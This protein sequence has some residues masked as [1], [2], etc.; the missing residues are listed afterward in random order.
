MRVFGRA[1]LRYADVMSTLAVF[2]ALGGG[3]LAALQGLPGSRGVFHG[4]VSR[5]SGALR[6]VVKPSA[7][8]R[9]KKGELAVSWNQQGLPGPATGTAG[10]DLSG[11]YP[12][13]IIAAGAVTGAKIA[14]GSVTAANV[15][16]ANIDGPPA[17]PSLRTLG[18][19]AQ[20][21]AAGDDPRL[22]TG[23]IGVE[24]SSTLAGPT[25][26]TFS[27]TTHKAGSVLLVTWSGTAFST[28]GG[29]G[30]LFLHVEVSPTQPDDL[31]QL[32]FNDTNK[33]LA[34]PASE[35]VFTG[36]SPGDH[37]LAIFAVGAATTDANDRYNVTCIEVVPNHVA[38]NAALR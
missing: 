24:H 21:A 38:T 26:V 17:A 25:P 35:A 29:I 30:E 15:A 14:A 7:C 8:R 32:E 36:L 37:T 9:G 1:R 27:C 16:G 6:L 4:C 18:R 34:F 12:N 23:V 11:R 3:S 33:H 13:P 10:G 5:R 28:T 22:S 31:T 19:G 2:L 20:Q